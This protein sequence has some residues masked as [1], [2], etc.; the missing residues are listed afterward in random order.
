MK[1][2]KKEWGVGAGCVPLP[3]TRDT[4]WKGV[5]LMPLLSRVEHGAL[6]HHLSQFHPAPTQF[7][8]RKMVNHDEPRNTPADLVCS[9]QKTEK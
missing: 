9:A 6:K 1:S 8:S 2:T 4:H 5:E 3:P 7:V